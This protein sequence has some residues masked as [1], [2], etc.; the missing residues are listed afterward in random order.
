MVRVMVKVRARASGV[1]VMVRVMVKVWARARV[2]LRCW[3]QVC[4]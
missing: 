1:R 2:N 3:G 4:S